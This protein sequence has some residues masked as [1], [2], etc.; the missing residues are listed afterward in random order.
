MFERQKF[1]RVTVADDVAFETQSSPQHV[2]KIIMAAGDR[3]TVV[4]IVGAH[5][6]QWVGLANHAFIR[7]EVNHLGFARRDL[8]VGARVAFAPA[9]VVRVNG[10]MFHR[11][12]DVL[13]LNPFHHLDGKF[14][15]EEWIFAVRF[16]A[17][18]PARIAQYIQD[19][20]INIR[21]AQG[22]RL[23]SGHFANLPD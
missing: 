21:V 12:N 20:R 2:G 23:A 16:L 11:R 13:A 6:A 19:G 15:N 3:N 22:V 10:E 5:H 9:L 7:P 8:R 1:N 14:G 18:S 4:I 17:T